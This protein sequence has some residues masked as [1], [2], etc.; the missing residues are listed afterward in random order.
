[1]SWLVLAILAYLVLALVNLADK[2]LL[3]KVLPSSLTY[4][5]LVGLLSLLVFLLAPWFL[6]WPGFSFWL[7]NIITGALFPLALLLLYRCLKEG[8]ASLV[9]PL[10]GGAAQIF[11]ILLA[12]I[13]LGEVFVVKQWLALGLLLSG[14]IMISW[15][16][17]AHHW[18]THTFAWFKLSGSKHWLIIFRS[19]LAAFIFAVFM[20]LSKYAYNH[21]SFL[22]AFIWIRLGTFVGVLFL[23]LKI[24]RRREIVKH[25]KRLFKGQ[26]EFLFLGNQALAAMGA[27]LQQYAI[28]LGSVAL[29]NALQGVQYALLL[30][31][32]GLIAVFYPK[33]MKENFNHNVIIQKIIA[34]S[35]ISLGLYFIVS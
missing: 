16:P 4:T 27:F 31:F 35:L 34:V 22:S 8:E 18:W 14:T 29:V 32:G 25:L 12:I 13:F 17:S 9:I 7:V 20:I 1:M 30:A 23:L 5:F 33:V 3:E 28:F 21:Q 6:E 24:K 2:F 10:I 19:M 11:T 15:F 26:R